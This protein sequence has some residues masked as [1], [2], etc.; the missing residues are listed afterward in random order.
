MKNQRVLVTGGAGFIGSNLAGELA[1]E[2]E[3]VIIDD[4]STGR[5]GNITDL[6]KTG[7]VRFVRGSITDIEL[8]RGSFKDIDYVFHQAALASVPG[9]IDDPVASNNVNINGTLNV[10]IAARDNNVKKVIIA[11]SCAVYGD[12]EV[13]PVA[14][15]A[16]L[17]PKSPYAVTKLACEYYC[18]VFSEV[19]DLPAVSL[20][21]FNV[22]GPHQNPGS[23]YAAVVPKFINRVISARP[24]VIYGDGLQTRDFVFVKDVVRA[25]ILAAESKESGVFNVGSG[26][27][28][29]VAELAGTI[30]GLLGKDMKPLHEA[31]REGEIRN[32]VAD[33]SKAKAIGYEAGYS[34]EEGLGETMGWFKTGANES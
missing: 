21:Y 30:T 19:Y 20:R 4:L 17:N 26:V 15:T 28:I 7:N 14:E 24:P 27:S 18:N 33:I 16:Q 1:L 3:V 32:S 25:N 12:P 23:E 34:L 9:S 13:M 8:L 31:Q 29:T 10:L 11:S 6:L 5:M 22:Y 2:N